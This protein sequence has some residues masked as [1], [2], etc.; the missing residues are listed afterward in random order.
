MKETYL[1]KTK[2]AQQLYL[3]HA[4]GLPII[5]FHNHVSVA[6]IASDRR[7]ENLY[8]LWLAS[9]PYKHRLMRI[10][11]VDE[12]FI[13]GDA[14]PYEKFE[15][16]CEVFPHLAGNPVYDWS[17]MELSRI[18]G[19]E[20]LP[21]KE[22]ARYLYDQCG[23]MLSSREFSGNAILSRFHIE[24]QSPV[25]TLLDDLSLFDGKT[26]APSLRGD[27]LLAPT[28]EFEAMLLERTGITV[29]D[30]ESY[31]Q[32][33]A[34][35]LDQFAQKG[36]RFADHALDA[37]FFVGDTDGK[38]A[39]ILALLGIE[40][41]KRGWTLLLHLDAK[42]KTSSRL[43]RVAGP[44]GGYASVGGSFDL[45]SLCDLLGRMEEQGPHQLHLFQALKTAQ[46]NCLYH[47]QNPKAVSVFYRAFQ[48]PSSNTRCDLC[49]RHRL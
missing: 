31:I 13:T 30:T 40:Y 25:A 9:D 5:D 7:F 26:V 6:D 2:G 45:S 14:S 46:K 34:V 37:G 3:E 18:F 21:T 4:K 47:R 38:K 41:A 35:I 48:I 11:G 24:Y 33:V 17:R 28:P 8:E 44:A 20:E 29:T 15:K 22:R 36:C 16:Y 32:A 42:R 1:L 39:E 49:S 23:E 27:E 43:A 12:R 10:C 19:I